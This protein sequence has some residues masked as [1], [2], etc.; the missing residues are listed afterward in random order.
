MV[1]CGADC[2][3][4]CNCV[5]LRSKIVMEKKINV[6]FVAKENLDFISELF[7]KKQP[8]SLSSILDELERLSIE[9]K[10]GSARILPGMLTYDTPPQ[11]IPSR[12]DKE[13]CY[14]LS[15]AEMQKLKEDLEQ[16]LQRNDE[17]NSLRLEDL[18]E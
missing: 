1:V 13:G 11:V 15:K 17:C 6:D 4:S 5:T 10:A 9:V 2:Q 18:D 16:Y 7:K 14:I 8:A 12:T 3:Y